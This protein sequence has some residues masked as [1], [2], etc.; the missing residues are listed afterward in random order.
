MKFMAFYLGDFRFPNAKIGDLMFD[1]NVENQMFEMRAEP[2]T[3]YDV[4]TIVDNDEWIL[5]CGNGTRLDFV[6]KAEFGELNSHGGVAQVTVHLTT[7]Y[8]A[9]N[10]K[11]SFLIPLVCYENDEEF[12]GWRRKVIPNLLVSLYKKWGVLFT[13]TIYDDHKFYKYKAINYVAD[14]YSVLFT[15]KN[16]LYTVQFRVLNDDQALAYVIQRYKND[17]LEIKKLKGGGSL[18]NDTVRFNREHAS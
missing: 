12:K 7:A 8:G 18:R 10:F 5:M 14:L 17:W 16:K 2:K 13:A 15:R 1:F 9:R 11:K 3:A 4:N 6:D